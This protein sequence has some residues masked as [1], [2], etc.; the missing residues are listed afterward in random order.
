MRIDALTSEGS[1]APQEHADRV[2]KHTL[3][4]AT[5]LERLLLP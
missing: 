4:I 3:S 5:F 2:A 1:I